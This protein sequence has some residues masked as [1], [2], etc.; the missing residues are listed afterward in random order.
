VSQEVLTQVARSIRSF[1]YEPARGRFRGWLG[2]VTRRKIARFVAT[3][4]RGDRAAGGEQADGHLEAF[5]SP[6]TDTE[7]TSA[8]Q[9]RILQVA[10]ARVRHDFEPATWDAFERI[11]LDDRPTAET[12]AALGLTIDAVYAAKSRVLKRLREEVVALAEDLPLHTLR[13]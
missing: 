4:D 10:L 9:D 6:E 3:R 11:W 5:E 12:A 1:E 13:G 7:W 2:T 8:F